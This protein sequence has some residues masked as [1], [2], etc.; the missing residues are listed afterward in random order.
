[1]TNQ[2]VI[3][4]SFTFIRALWRYWLKYYLQSPR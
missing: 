1:M 4:L 2:N 3:E